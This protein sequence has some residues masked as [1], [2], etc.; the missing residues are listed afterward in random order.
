MYQNKQDSIYLLFS[1]DK[2]TSM[3]GAAAFNRSCARSYDVTSSIDIKHKKNVDWSH[4][5]MLG[6]A[7]DVNQ[8]LITGWSCLRG[9]VNR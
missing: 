5:Q 3:S 2:I 9:R 8:L 6:K 4:L 7:I 1:F